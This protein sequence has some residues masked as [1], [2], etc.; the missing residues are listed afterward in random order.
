M[1][2]LP[3]LPQEQDAALIP[4]VGTE[5]LL[6]SLVSDGDAEE[7]RWQR[8]LSP[9]AHVQEKLERTGTYNWCC[10]QPQPCRRFSLHYIDG[11]MGSRPD[12]PR[13][14]DRLYKAR[15]HRTS[16]TRST[17]RRDGE[18]LLTI[19]VWPCTSPATTFI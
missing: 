9:R 13:H 14:H 16:R 6:W 8:R 2:F 7:L 18:I 3:S 12:T 4:R 15:L 5:T 10:Q 19:M 1:D 11:Y 17:R